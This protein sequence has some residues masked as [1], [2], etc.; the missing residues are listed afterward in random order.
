VAV[1]M[2]AE[3][4]FFTRSYKTPLKIQRFKQDRAETKNIDA[5][6]D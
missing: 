5:A 3:K 6:H 2:L 4:S 1:A